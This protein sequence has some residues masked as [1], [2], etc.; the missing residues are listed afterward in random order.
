MS[1]R[2]APA[3]AFA[4]IDDESPLLEGV[5]REE[6]HTGKQREGGGSILSLSA[7]LTNTLV[8]T[9]CLAL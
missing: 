4:E 3:A 8:G 1:P 7:G 9:G 5:E 2:T 6:V